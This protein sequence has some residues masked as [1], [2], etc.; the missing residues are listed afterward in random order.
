MS[1]VTFRKSRLEKVEAPITAGSISSEETQATVKA[2]L[3]AE[4]WKAKF[5]TLKDALDYERK[6]RKEVET[7]LNKLAYELGGVRAEVK[8]LESRIKALTGTVE[9]PAEKAEVKSE[10]EPR[11]KNQEFKKEDFRI[12]PQIP[13]RKTIQVSDSTE[14]PAIFVEYIGLSKEVKK[15]EAAPAVADSAV[16]APIVSAP[17]MAAQSASAD[18]EVFSALANSYKAEA[19]KIWNFGGAILSAFNESSPELTAEHIQNFCGHVEWLSYEYGRYRDLVPVINYD[20]RN[21]EKMLSQV[22]DIQ[23]YFQQA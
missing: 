15:E 19:E 14:M 13:R 21:L 22:R 6:K 1:R 11:T 23:S 8:Q 3:E 17:V 7:N 9:A 10:T 2:L 16:S 12:E 5:E 4:R 18:E 20:L